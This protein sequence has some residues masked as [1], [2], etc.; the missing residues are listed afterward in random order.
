MCIVGDV[1]MRCYYRYERQLDYERQA[2]LRMEE[3]RVQKKKL[4]VV[5]VSCRVVL[6]HVMSCLYMCYVCVCC[7]CSCV[8]VFVYL[9]VCVVCVCMYV[10]V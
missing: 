9:C 5:C 1:I 2:A 6:C 10:C 4:L 8:C 3:D 7:V